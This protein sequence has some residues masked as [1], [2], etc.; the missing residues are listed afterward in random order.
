MEVLDGCG[1][2]AAGV[3]AL[4]DPQ[5]A[6]VNIGKVTR[7]PT[8][9][10]RVLAVG[11]PKGDVFA[12]IIRQAT[13]LGAT[14]IWPL[15]TERTEVHLDESRAEKKRDRWRA[16][17]LESCKQS[18]NPWLPAIHAPR[19][20]KAWLKEPAA[21]TQAS[22]RFVAALTPDAVAPSSFPAPL[23]ALIGVGPEGD[24]TAAEYDAFRQAGFAPVRLPGHVLRVE[25]ACV[26]ALTL[27]GAA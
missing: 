19:E 15:V 23:P 1:G 4:A 21:Q 17:A 2:I 13:E 12:E 11:L 6:R 10:P 22:R 24:F 25:T 26:A 9:P 27:L 14:E 16:V 3:L 7:H 8:P 5:S 18:G 20:L